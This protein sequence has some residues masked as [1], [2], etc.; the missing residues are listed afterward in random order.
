MADFV[1]AETESKK[2]CT[3]R[4]K[5]SAVHFIEGKWNYLCAI[6]ENGSGTH[7]EGKN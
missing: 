2:D 6:L 7:K 3:H 5:G 1:A 4:E